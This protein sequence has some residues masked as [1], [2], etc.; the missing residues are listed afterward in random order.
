[1]N[2]H[3]KMILLYGQ[4]EHKCTAHKLPKERT[5]SQFYSVLK[6]TAAAQGQ[7]TLIPFYWSPQPRGNQQMAPQRTGQNYCVQEPSSPTVPPPLCR[8]SR[9]LS[10][11]LMLQTLPPKKQSRSHSTASATPH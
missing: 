8:A 7:Y 3:Y 9:G 2:L 6:W 5:N 10:E 4:R 11:K 1:M